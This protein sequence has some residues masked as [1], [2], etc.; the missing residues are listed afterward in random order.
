MRR[1]WHPVKPRAECR[2]SLPKQSRRPLRGFVAPTFQSAV[3]QALVCFYRGAAVFG[4]SSFG[5]LRCFDP[6]EGLARF[7]FSAPGDGR[8]PGKTCRP[9]NLWTPRETQASPVFVGLPAGKPA[10]RQVGKPAPRKA[11][12]GSSRPPRRPSGTARNE[13]GRSEVTNR[14]TFFGYQGR[15]LITVPRGP[16]MRSVTRARFPVMR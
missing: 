2:N 3:S 5:K 4:R 14:L 13:P 15:L 10:I 7:C 8:T 12:G 16:W 6:F 11:A 9:T 1:E